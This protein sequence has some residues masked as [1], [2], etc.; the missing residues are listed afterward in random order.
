MPPVLKAFLLGGGP[1]PAMLATA[2]PYLSLLP[3]EGVARNGDAPVRK[4]A[5]LELG[6]E[7]VTLLD[8]TAKVP[9]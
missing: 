6:G 3:S 8:K 2:L 5:Y 7:I 1:G 4:I 9:E